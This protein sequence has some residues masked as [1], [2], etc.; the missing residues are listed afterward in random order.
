LQHRIEIYLLDMDLETTSKRTNKPT[1]FLQI[2]SGEFLYGYRKYTIVYNGTN[3]ALITFRT[4]T[5]F[6]KRGFLLYF[7]GNK[8]YFF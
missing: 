4:D 7:K 6:N 8:Y 2:N 5:F 1:D 3:D